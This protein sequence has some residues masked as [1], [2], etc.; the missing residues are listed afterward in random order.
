MMKNNKKKN[1]SKKR[2]RIKKYDWKDILNEDFKRQLINLNTKKKIFQILKNT[3]LSQ[4]FIV[5]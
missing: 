2:E 5:H 3:N 1:F 4:K